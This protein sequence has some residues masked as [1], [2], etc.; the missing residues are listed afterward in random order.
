MLVP[1]VMAQEWDHMAW[2]VK[3]LDG[4]LGKGMKLR[5]RGVV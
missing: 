5:F 2:E 3:D 4:G 1:R